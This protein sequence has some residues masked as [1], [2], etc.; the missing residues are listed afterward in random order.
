MDKLPGSLEISGRLLAGVVLAAEP[1]PLP[2]PLLPPEL[3]DPQPPKRA[4]PPNIAPAAR[5]SRRFTCCMRPLLGLTH[6]RQARGL[7]LLPL[8]LRRRDAGGRQQPR[9]IRRQVQANRLP[10]L[11]LPAAVALHQ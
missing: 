11:V 6:W 9:G 3:D 10:R 2:L 8:R 5:K 4:A 1:P 7:R